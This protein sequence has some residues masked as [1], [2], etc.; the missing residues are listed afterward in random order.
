VPIKELNFAKQRLSGVTAPQHRARLAVAMA[1]DV[2]ETLRKVQGLTGVM[3]MTVDAEIKQLAHRL[4]AIVSDGSARNGHTV[5][6]NAA[7]AFLEAAGCKAM[8]TIPADIPLVTA[9]EVERLLSTY[10]AQPSV[11]LVASRDGNGTNAALCS[12]PTALSFAFGPGSFARRIALARGRG[13]E[14]R[15]VYAPGIALDIDTPED[16][17]QLLASTS[18]THSRRY[19][20]AHLPA[21]NGSAAEVARREVDR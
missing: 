6:V 15:L 12:P 2:L 11:T 3:V 5:V 18:N 17:R 20:L 1:T 19:C 10:A 16:L 14:P 21:F 8:L 9:T 4:G 7:G 13:L